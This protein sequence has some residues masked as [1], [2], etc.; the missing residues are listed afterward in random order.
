MIF[1]NPLKFGKFRRSLEVVISQIHQ[2]ET[3]IQNENIEY[4]KSEKSANV[5]FD[6]CRCVTLYTLFLLETPSLASY[7]TV[8]VSLI[9]IKIKIFR[10]FLLPMYEKL[11]VLQRPLYLRATTT[12]LLDAFK[13]IEH[14]PDEKKNGNEERRKLRFCFNLISN[15][16]TNN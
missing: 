12:C 6:L 13:I 1:L 10:H 11:A 4:R 5:T 16:V 8:P 15:N 9:K 2:I 3:R 7:G 14:S